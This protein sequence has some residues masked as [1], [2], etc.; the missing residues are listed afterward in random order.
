MFS[1]LYFLYLI[2]LHILAAIG[3]CLLWRMSIGRGATI[4]D[5]KVT[6]IEVPDEDDG[7]DDEKWNDD[8][9]AW[10]TATDLLMMFKHSELQKM[11]KDRGISSTIRGKC[12]TKAEFIEALLQTQSRASDHQMGFMAGLMRKNHKLVI[13]PEDID[14]KAAASKWIAHAKSNEG[15]ATEAGKCR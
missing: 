12:R 6:L 3:V 9:R 11:S 10:K 14:S 1:A 2:A 15:R 13:D 7:S 5:S 4:R 8:D